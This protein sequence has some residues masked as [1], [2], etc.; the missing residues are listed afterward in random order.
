MYHIS[1]PYF[2]RV[3][4]HTEVVNVL[5]CD[6]TVKEF[7]TQSRYQVHFWTNIL[8]NGMKYLSPP[9]NGL[10]GTIPVS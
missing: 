1:E 10:H 3:S 4:R 6:I 8:G 9:S 2:K 7:E 5:N